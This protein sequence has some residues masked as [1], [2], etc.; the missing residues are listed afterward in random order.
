M[1]SRF[2]NF[3]SL[4]IE[5]NRDIQRIKDAEMGKFGLKASHTMCLYYLSQHPEGLTATKLTELCI[6]DKAA[7]SRTLRQLSD[8]ELIYCDQP[9]GPGGGKRTYRSLYY[10][11]DKGAELAKATVNAINEA[12]SRVGLDM[13][14]EN[15]EFLYTSLE[16]IRDN[17]SKYLESEKK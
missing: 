7:I 12:M 17:L 14:A 15:R 1:S 6:I 2:E 5:I 16:E 11:T 13:S 8:K 9:A 10:L 3:L 4:I